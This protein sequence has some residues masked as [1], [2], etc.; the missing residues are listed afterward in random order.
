MGKKAG[1]VK[2]K[3]LLLL[4][5]HCLLYLQQVLEGVVVLVEP[6]VPDGHDEVEEGLEPRVLAGRALLH[7]QDVVAVRPSNRSYNRNHSHT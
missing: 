4:I 3:V 7:P 1:F 5:L 2:I 6:R